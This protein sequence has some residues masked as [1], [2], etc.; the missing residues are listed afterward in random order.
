MVATREYKVIGTRPIRPDGADKVTG[1]AEFGADIRLPGMLY[2][3]VKRS[4][5][6]HALIKR[7]D[8]SRALALPGVKAVVTAADFPPAPDI[9][10]PLGEQGGPSPL[11]Y[12]RDAILASSKVLYVGHPVAAVCASDPHV[13]EDALDLIEVE[14]EALPFVQD[15]REAMAAGAPILH[16][17]LK[18][19]AAQPLAETLSSGPT[20]VA[21]LTRFARG[22]I[23][24]GFKEAD[25]V[26]EREF[27]TSMF[28]QGYIEPQNG[29][30]Y[31]NKDG[32]LIIWSS[33]QGHFMVRSSCANLLQLPISQV[34]AVP[35]EI[36]G[37]FG[38]K[39]LVYLEPVAAL[40]SK[41]S[42]RPVKVTMSRTEVLEATGPTSGSY[43]RVKLGAKR[44][45]TITAAQ[46]YLAFE[47]GAYPGSPVGAAA[48]C[49][50]GPYALANTQVDA[51]DVVLNK[52]KVASYRAPGAPASEFAVETVINE[53]AE[54]LKIDPLDL[55][56]KNAAREGAPGPFG[57]PLGPVGAV[58]VIE[59]MQSHPHYR[60]ELQG[61]NRGRGVAM[62]FWFNAAGVRSVSATLNPDG[63]VGLTTGN[64][65]IGGTRS[66]IAIMLA[67]T[68]GIAAE[69]VKPHIVPTDDVGDTGMTGGSSS[70]FS[71]G[72][73]VYEVG[74][75]LRK[76]LVERAARIWEV[77]ADQVE[78]G[79]D[80]VL[81]GPNDAEGKPRSL[82]F[83]QI[84]S[85]LPRTGGSIS[86]AVTVQRQGNAPAYA[87]HIVDVAVDRE[88]GK[89]E[90]LRYT[91]F[92][93]CGTAIHPSYVEGQVQGGVVQ[94]VG[95][96]LTEE[97]V[98]GPDG[99]MLNTSL[100]DYRMPTALDLPMIDAVL[101]EVP[102]P[103]HP[104]GVRGVGEVSI[105]PPMA[106]IQAAIADATGVRLY[107]APMSPKVVLEALVDE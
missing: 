80:G 58:A 102:N 39:T 31:W 92:Q 71:S 20:N 4:P 76:K 90:I 16:D 78:Y 33:S 82:T 14:Y 5:L 37:G 28:H 84:C 85:Q 27:E 32:R 75:E 107:R 69:D 83:K 99:R 64:V 34:N 81:R 63:A 9:S 62:G 51:Y 103:N 38:G 8:V 36:G 73:A 41:K 106:A 88:T 46:I 10:T 74:Q 61:D 70:T 12:Q 17:D 55:R 65:D 97:Y 40:L 93:D 45:G 89:V 66:S 54:Q 44:D 49:S 68:L 56:L 96:A 57:Q 59:A 87:G 23:E 104:F 1:R 21:S 53:L 100:L 22:D 50:L 30:A 101:I 11:R 3:R 18:T 43:M 7:I 94:G 72:W 105:V 26:I 52:P 86:A 60:S 15:V 91:A 67:E 2:G 24:A 25:A 19:R 95:M 98:W 47:A 6:P 13:A 35:M 77:P 29:T 79:D 48:L 42:G